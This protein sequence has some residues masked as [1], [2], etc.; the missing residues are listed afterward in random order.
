MKKTQ[1]IDYTVPFTILVILFFFVGFLTTAN[2]QFQ[3]PLKE[4]FL[5]GAGD[6]KNTFATLISFAWFLAY[7]LTG[8]T[9][10]SWV[11]RYGHRNT[12][13][14]GLIILIVGLAL[15]WFSS[16][17]TG[18]FPSSV[19]AI[20]D[21]I[22]PWGYV[23]FL[24][25]SYVVGAAAAVLQVVINPYLSACT[26]R[27][28]QPVQRLNMG[29]AANSVGTTLAPF[30]V[31]GIVFG[32]L[33]MDQIHVGQIRGAFLCLMLVFLVVILILSRLELPDIS[34]TKV[35]AEDDMTQSI[36][37]F[38]HLTLGVIALFFYV[39]VEVCIGA[40]INLYTLDLESKG[41]IF[42]FFGADSFHIGNVKMTI[43]TWMVT[44]Y[45]GGMLV[46][47]LV[48]SSLNKI[49]SRVQLGVAASLA[50][51]STL[52]AIWLDEPWFLVLVG[53]FHSVM[54]GAI[55][56]LAIA[57]LG[58]YTAKGSGMLMIGVIGGSLLPLLQGVWADACQGEWRY[59]WFIVIMGEAY[60]LYYALRGSIV[61]VK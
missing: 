46:G 52:V 18:W 58:K 43:P 33:P 27:N 55:F 13:I 59:T 17:Y 21:A 8:G 26:V 10:A 29:G 14:R 56:S 54:W 12:L 45:W 57:K 53:L 22:I 5:T 41:R 42:S 23:I 49:S 20:S 11:V 39:G 7:P 4:T 60:I 34:E 36:W 24:I 16:A 28:T 9:A 50:L 1:Q 51:V 44:L 31:T 3:G 30:F 35:T 19:F 6:L 48:S 37:S 25:G 32:G 38:R 2:G 40:N 47:R 15:F 61:K